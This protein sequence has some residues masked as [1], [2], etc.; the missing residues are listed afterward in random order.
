VN[1]V[2]L[3]LI[4]VAVV[5]GIRWFMDWRRRQGSAAKRKLLTWLAIG[6]LLFLTVTGKLNVIVPVLVTLFAALL[7]FAPLLLQ[8]LPVFQRAWRQHRNHHAASGGSANR[9]SADTQY[10]QVNLNHVTG[11][12]SGRVTGGRYVGRDLHDLSISELLELH[13]ECRQEDAD[14]AAV[15]E[16]YLDRVHGDQWRNADQ[17]RGESRAGGRP[18]I[19]PDD[20]YRVL[21]LTPGASREAIIQ[22]HRRLMQKLHPDRGGSDYLAAEINRAKEILLG[23][24]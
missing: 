6:V 24:S 3:L 20:A 8:L 14:S 1:P 21:G 16:A 11:E 4:L 10:V 15:L 22:A 19:S 12:I 18:E 2:L 13:R 23:N 5:L 17:N 9:S 7:R